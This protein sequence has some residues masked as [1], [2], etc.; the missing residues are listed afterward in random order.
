MKKNMKYNQKELIDGSDSKYVGRMLTGAMEALVGIATL[1]VEVSFAIE[2]GQV[3]PIGTIG[4]I[5]FSCDG[6]RRFIVSM[7]DR[8]E[9][10]ELREKAMKKKQRKENKEMQKKELEEKGGMVR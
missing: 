7:N 4:G 5:S 3:T 1:A 10:K 8:K 9:Y 6:I 2:T